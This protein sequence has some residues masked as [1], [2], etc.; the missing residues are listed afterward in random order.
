MATRKLTYA[1]SVEIDIDPEGLAT[2]TTRTV[3]V[4]SAAILNTANLYLDALVGGK[5]TTG[6]S[7]TAGKQVDVWVYAAYKDT[8]TYPDTID[9]TKSGETITSEN[10]RNAAMKLGASIIVDATSDRTYFVAPFSIAELFGGVLP[11]HWGLFVA[12][13]TAVNL[14]ATN[15]N[16]EFWHTGVYETMV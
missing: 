16:H 5:I 13:D 4:E 10:V 7:P 2:S 9:G 3:G 6:T 14:H 1:A 12:H 15:T 8:P 11:T